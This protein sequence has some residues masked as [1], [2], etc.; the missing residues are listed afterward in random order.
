MEYCKANDTTSAPCVLLK[1]RLDTYENEN[2]GQ[3]TLSRM[4][5]RWYDDAT[6]AIP[7]LSMTTEDKRMEKEHFAASI[8]LESSQ[9]C[10]ASIGSKTGTFYIDYTTTFHHCF[11]FCFGC[12]SF[13]SFFILDLSLFKKQLKKINQI[14]Q[15]LITTII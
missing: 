10:H 4:L 13:L 1:S 8:K 12:H 11:E 2:G 15:Q 6:I 5:R 9:I 14:V 3:N 7:R